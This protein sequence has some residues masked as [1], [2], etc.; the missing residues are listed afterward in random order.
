MAVEQWDGES[1][2]ENW[3]ASPINN[4]KLNSVAAYNELLPEFEALLARSSDMHTFFQRC[5]DLAELDFHQ[6]RI[7]LSSYLQSA[8]R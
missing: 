7:E 5:S 3:V 8:G 6:R 2:F 4:A 1:P